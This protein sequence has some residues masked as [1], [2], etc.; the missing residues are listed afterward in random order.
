MES[1]RAIALLRRMQEPEAYEPQ[2]TEEAYEALD[3]AMK[4]LAVM[5]VVAEECQKRDLFQ[6]GTKRG[7][8]IVDKYGFTICSEC[9]KPRRDNR[10]DHIGWCN[11]CGAKMEET[12]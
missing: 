11:G 10:I 8:W 1:R 5:E 2:I 12:C 6:P 9:R 3:L 7:K 4:S